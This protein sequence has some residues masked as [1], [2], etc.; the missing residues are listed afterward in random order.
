MAHRLTAE[1]EMGESFK[2][3]GFTVGER[4]DAL[5]LAA[6]DRSHMP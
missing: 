6:G 3:V 1:H 5:G 2:V 4:F